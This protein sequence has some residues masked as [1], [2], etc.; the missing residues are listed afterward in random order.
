MEERL[1]FVHDALHR[2]RRD[3]WLDLGDPPQHRLT[4]DVRRTRLH[5]HRL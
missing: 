4:S 1:R 5:H 2:F 3:W